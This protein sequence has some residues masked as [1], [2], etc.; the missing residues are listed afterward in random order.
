MI[1]LNPPI[2]ITTPSGK[3]LAH[4]LIDPGTEHELL[5]VCFFDSNGECWTY[6]NQEIRSQRNITY[7]RTNISPFYNPE[8][9]AFK[10]EDDLTKDEYKNMYNDNCKNLQ[11]L[12]LKYHDLQEDFDK[13]KEILRKQ[14]G[15]N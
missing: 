3:A 2:P 5:W 1:Q 4:F 9:V 6:R 7:G 10:N 11:H 13:L 8:D 12:M 14:H 15:L